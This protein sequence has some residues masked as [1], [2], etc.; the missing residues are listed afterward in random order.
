[1]EAGPLLQMAKIRLDHRIETLSQRIEKLAETIRF[2]ESNS[3]QDLCGF[4]Y[5]EVVKTKKERDQLLEERNDAHDS[6]ADLESTAE[7]LD[8]VLALRR[9]FL[10]RGKSMLSSLPAE[11]VHD[12][13]ECADLESLLS[14]GRVL[15]DF[16]KVRLQRRR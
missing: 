15:D 13:G 14:V 7:S 8:V 11:A 5:M 1:M 9:C 3:F 12:V 16:V 6:L 2:Y 10:A 4:L